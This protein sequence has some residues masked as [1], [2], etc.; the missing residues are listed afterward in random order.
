MVKDV[1]AN[2]HSGYRIKLHDIGLV[3]E[4]LIGG[5]YESAYCTKA[6]KQ[7]YERG[8]PRSNTGQSLVN[9]S[10]ADMYDRDKEQDFQYPFNDL[11]IWAVLTKRQAMALCM[12]ER[13]DEGLAKVSLSAGSF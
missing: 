5:D 7:A 4:K 9:G 10:G 2:V 8:R 6:F 12:W 1:V 11:F 13:G 3:I